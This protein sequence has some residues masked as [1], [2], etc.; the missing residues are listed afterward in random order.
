MIL[1]C[2]KNS[3][4][5]WFCQLSPVLVLHWFQWEAEGMALTVPGPEDWA[6]GFYKVSGKHGNR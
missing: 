2:G 6:E 3:D 5:D 1:N 4:P